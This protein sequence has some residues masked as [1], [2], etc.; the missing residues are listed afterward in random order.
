ML[1]IIKNKKLRMFIIIFIV[2]VILSA[3]TIFVLNQ[4]KDN[5]RSLYEVGEELVLEQ[6][7]Y[8]MF[9]EIDIETKM[10][11]I[12]IKNSMDNSAKLVV[13]GE[14]DYIKFT[15]KNNKLF[16]DINPKNFIAL[17]LYSY[18][19]KIE[20]YLPTGYEKLIRIESEFGNI[21]LDE[22][23]SSTFDIRQ[24]YGNLLS[25]GVDFLKIY[26][27]YGNIDILSGK[28][29]RVYADYGSV[30]VGT[31]ED[32][33]IENNYGDIDVESISKYLNIENDSGDININNISLEKDS[34]ISNN[35]GDI[36]LGMTNEIKIT[37]KTDRGNVNIQNNYKKSEISLKI[38]NKDGDINV[39]N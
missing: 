4:L 22:F 30:K 5:Y 34:S 26:N 27:T 24:D 6:N 2:L 13:Y 20:L 12:Y 17:D 23:I 36:N 32:L 1:K 29:L 18:I 33:V 11:D 21:E 25:K 16:I 19:S 35:Y 14:K 9:D 31:V 38:H 15:E 3:I 8:T 10:T 37:A 7:F 39:K 28:M